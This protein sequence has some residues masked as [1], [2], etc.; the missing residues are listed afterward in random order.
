M[1]KKLIIGI[2]LAV[3]VLIILSQSMF[4]ISEREQAIIT[5]LGEYKRTIAEP[6]LNAKL[7]FIQ[8]L[9]R[10]DRRVLALDA[11]PMEYLTGDKKR[12]LV[13]SVSRWR[14]ADPLLFFK[15]MRTEAIALLRMDGIISSQLREEFAAH[16]FGEIIG[17]QR[18]PI[19]ETV[20]KRA[21]NVMKE[22]GIEVVGVRI[23]RADLPPE[24]Q[25]SVFARMVA[26][27]NR[28]AMRYRA[29]GDEI[30]KSIRAI[31]DKE[32]TIILAD[33][34]KKSQILIGKGDAKAASIYAEAFGRNPEFFSFVRSLEAYEK[35]LGERDILL[36]GTDSDLFRYLEGPGLR[37]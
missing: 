17:E 11:P 1:Q 32:V 21:N 25:D 27:R 15:T 24:V 13:D 5:Q 36:L 4:I 26:E 33:A 28:I 29:E 18:E 12:L 37:R 10:F 7:P 9:K 2:A 3:S 31:A 20:A 22:F 30:G 35:L 8:D 34:F 16:T 6:G 14:I 23:K 19:M